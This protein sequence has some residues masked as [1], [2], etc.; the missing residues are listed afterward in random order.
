LETFVMPI[1]ELFE[2][3]AYEPR[4]IQIMTEAFDEALR[5]EGVADRTSVLAELIARRVLMQFQKG[6]VDP[7]R[8]AQ[9]VTGRIE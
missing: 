6:E 7:K 8:I 1:L 4:D 9:I 5:L 3:A 2:G